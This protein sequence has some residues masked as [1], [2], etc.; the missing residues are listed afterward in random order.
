MPV[1]AELTLKVITDTAS[2]LRRLSFLHRLSFGVNCVSCQKI[3][4]LSRDTTPRNSGQEPLKLY[5]CRKTPP[6]PTV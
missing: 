6:L 5:P 2:H 3:W 1:G 4:G